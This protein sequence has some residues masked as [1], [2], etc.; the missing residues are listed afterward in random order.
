MPYNLLV[1]RFGDNLK[2]LKQDMSPVTFKVQNSST[3]LSSGVIEEDTDLIKQENKLPYSAPDFGRE[4]TM[5][6]Q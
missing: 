1:V 3:L 2:G 4:S 5:V 6:S